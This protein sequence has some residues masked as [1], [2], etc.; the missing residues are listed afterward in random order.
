MIA[1]A[2][3]LHRLLGHSRRWLVLSAALAM[4]QAALLIPVGLLIKNA[5]D[6]A[7]PDGNVGALVRIG[8]LLLALFVASGVLGLL[9][10]WIVLSE[11][12]EAIARLRTALLERLQALPTRT[13]DRD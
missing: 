3:S 11:T 2:R 7:I 1:T 9:T 12:K 5:F 6:E 10:R 13:L 8:V 4:G